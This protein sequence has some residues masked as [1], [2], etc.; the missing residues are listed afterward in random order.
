MFEFPYTCGA[1]TKTHMWTIA[2]S[3]GLYFAAL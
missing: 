2:Q 1:E 3:E